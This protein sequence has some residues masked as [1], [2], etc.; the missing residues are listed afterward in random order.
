MCTL[1]QCTW[2]IYAHAS[3]ICVMRLCTKP[4]ICLYSRTYGHFEDTR[5]GSAVVDPHKYR[6]V[7]WSLCFWFP[8]WVRDCMIYLIGPFRLERMSLPTYSNQEPCGSWPLS[9]TLESWESEIWTLTHLVL[10][11]HLLL[12]SLVHFSY[13]YPIIEANYRASHATASILIQLLFIDEAFR[14]CSSYLL[15]SFCFFDL[16]SA[17]NRIRVVRSSIWFPP[18]AFCV[19]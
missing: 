1:Y 4:G 17:W 2:N 18:L 7:I 5:E 9:A 15:A 13:L 19:P 3:A 16:F 11:F 10:S 8:V 6:L 14:A 12:V